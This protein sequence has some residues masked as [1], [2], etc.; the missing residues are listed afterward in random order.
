M[1]I[2]SEQRNRFATFFEGDALIPSNEMT[3]LC[4]PLRVPAGHWE[5]LLTVSWQSGEHLAGSRFVHTKLSDGMPL[6]SEAI[7]AA[8]L[9]QIS[10]GRQMLRANTVFDNNVHDIELSVWQDSGEALGA[11]AVMELRPLGTYVAL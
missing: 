9:S 1:S 3:P 10:D 7:D 6:H 5:V 4:E 11:H 8:V 2:Q